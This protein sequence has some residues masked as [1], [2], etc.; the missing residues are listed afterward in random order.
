MRV[1]TVAESQLNL[2]IKALCL[3]YLCLFHAI[4]LEKKYAHSVRVCAV[5]CSAIVRIQWLLHVCCA[6]E[7]LREPLV[8]YIYNKYIYI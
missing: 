1:K 5:L 8:G 2:Y 3:Y 4:W 7:R 6:C